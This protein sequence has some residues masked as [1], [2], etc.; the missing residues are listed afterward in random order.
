MVPLVSRKPLSTFPPLTVDV[1][2]GALLGGV[3][4]L[5]MTAAESVDLATLAGWFEEHLVATGAMPRPVVLFEP[6]MNGVPLHRSDGDGDP[7][8]AM[9]ARLVAVARRRVVDTLQGF[10]GTP[11]KDDFLQAAIHLGRVHRAKSRWVAQPEIT[12]PLSG[13]VLS[14]FAVA[15]LTDRSACEHEL[16]VCSLCGRVSFDSRPDMRTSCLR[17]APEASGFMPRATWHGTGG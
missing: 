9:L 14:L 8:A 16:C 4:F 7:M 2:R 3:S 17:H 6:S 11:S 15:I 13:V 10:L 5:E 1:D 12:A